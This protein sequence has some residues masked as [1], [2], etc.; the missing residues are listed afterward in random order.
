[1]NVRELIPS[2]QMPLGRGEFLTRRDDEKDPLLTLHREMNRL[3]EEVYLGAF[4]EPAAA[5]PGIDRREADKKNGWP[6]V[7]VAKTA[8]E[9]KV[10]V[11]LPGLDEK[12][13][14][15]EL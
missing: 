11:E 8:K 3:F 1:M 12:D 15:V 2:R 10:I 7:E 5:P 9:M 4:H 6:Q 14:R 13:V